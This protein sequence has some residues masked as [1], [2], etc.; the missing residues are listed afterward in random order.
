MPPGRACNSTRASFGCG[1]WRGSS[2][3]YNP[4]A[5]GATGAAGALISLPAA[6]PPI[7]EEMRAVIL[8]HEISHGAF[9]TLPVY[10]HYAEAFW[11]SLTPA[12]RA[13]FT[14]FLGRQGY[15]TGN[16][17]LMLNETQ[18]YLIFTRDPRF[19]N[20]SVVNMSQ[21]QIDTLRA[22]YIAGIPVPWLK[23]MADASLPVAQSVPAC[24]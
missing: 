11:A 16:T 13:A 19:F 3:G 8:H 10:Q 4:A 9:Y 2:A 7:T 21:A 1:G 23:P 22:G 24:G 17:E 5:T 12:D 20:G 14:F 6:A 15:D 18:A